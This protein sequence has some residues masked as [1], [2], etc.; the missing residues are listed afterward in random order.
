MTD[1]PKPG[2]VRE[3][4]DLRA[5]VAGR[6]PEELHRARGLLLAE[7][8]AERGTGDSSHPAFPPR[9]PSRLRGTSRLRGPA[10]PP[11]WRG[12]RLAMLGGV[13]AAVVATATAITR[14][15]P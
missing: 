3:L 8:Q 11:A 7:I 9:G 10:R 14:I 15:L 6:A 12:P 13:T 5:D 2:P 1:L 4:T